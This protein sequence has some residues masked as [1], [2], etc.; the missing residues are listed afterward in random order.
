MWRK[1]CTIIIA[2]TWTV[3]LFA[4]I[5]TV[6]LKPDYGRSAVINLFVLA[7]IIFVIAAIALVR[8][9]GRDP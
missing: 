6:A 8:Q 9:I 1:L 7:I 4:G 3:L 5:A 2:L